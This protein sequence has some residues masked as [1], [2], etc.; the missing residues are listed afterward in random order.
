MLGS[1]GIG[2]HWHCTAEASS[3]EGGKVSSTVDL[4]VLRLGELAGFGKIGNECGREN[5]AAAVSLA[6]TTNR[7]VSDVC[8]LKV[9]DRHL[10]REV[11][12]KLRA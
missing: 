12:A 5:E 6:P 1:L 7:R 8:W 9:H 11:C 10:L 4:S 2:A 3:N